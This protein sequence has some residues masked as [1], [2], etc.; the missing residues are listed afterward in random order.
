MV[1]SGRALE[2][3]PSRVL[4]TFGRVGITSTTSCTRAFECERGEMRSSGVFSATG[5]ICGIEHTVGIDGGLELG[6]ECSPAGRC[7]RRRVSA[8]GPTCLGRY[9]C[10]EGAFTR[11]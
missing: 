3:G 1:G 7:A 8:V 5:A 4:R 9:A 6:E 10:P 2:S 11:G